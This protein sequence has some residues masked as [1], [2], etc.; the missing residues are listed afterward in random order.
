M[1]VGWVPC[2]RGGTPRSWAASSG[3]CDRRRRGSTVTRR[4]ERGR[5]L[6]A[7][8]AIEYVTYMENDLLYGDHLLYAM[9]HSGNT[10]TAYSA[11]QS[12][13]NTHRNA[14]AK[15]KGSLR[16]YMT[17]FSS[18]SF[19]PSRHYWHQYILKMTQVCSFWSCLPV[20]TVGAPERIVWRRATYFVLIA[21][22]TDSIAPHPH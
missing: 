22:L 1:T 6:H 15:K 12:Y 5:W 9:M 7:E 3:S 16:G 20:T 11:D 10:S 17:P 18:H 14:I 13:A 8:H 4:P 19:R 2:K 21:W